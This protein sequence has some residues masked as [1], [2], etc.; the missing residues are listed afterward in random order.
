MLQN[1]AYRGPRDALSKQMFIYI[2]PHSLI[3]SPPSLFPI[4]GYISFVQ[5]HVSHTTVLGPNSYVQTDSRIFM[6][7]TALSS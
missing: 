6:N 1:A 7:L 2:N 4:S 5:D 3:P